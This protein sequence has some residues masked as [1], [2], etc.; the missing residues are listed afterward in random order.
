MADKEEDI[1]SDEF[2]I[3]PDD[4]GE[5][6]EFTP[7]PDTGEPPKK[8]KKPESSSDSSGRG[9]RRKAGILGAIV[10]GLIIGGSAYGVQAGLIGSEPFDSSG[11]HYGIHEGF[12]GDRCVTQEEFDAMQE[13]PEEKEQ[14]PV[15]TTPPPSSGGT[16]DVSSASDKVE[17]EKTKEVL[18]YYMV[19]SND[20]WY[21]DY[22]DFRKIPSKIEEK[23]DMKISF[24]CYTDDFA[25]TSTYFAT[26]RNVLQDH[27]QVDVYLRDK[28]VETKS[29]DTNKALILEGSCY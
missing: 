4:I 29:T 18:G 16:K 3:K 1:F 12:L 20:D 26:F 15:D 14:K 19:K 5:Q 22:V 24:R 11:C 13:K 21:G 8:P 6:S 9:S 10:I 17:L 28:L 27:L 25:G 2:K 7:P 23:G